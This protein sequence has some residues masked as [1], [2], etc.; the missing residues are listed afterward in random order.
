MGLTGWK[1]AD[2]RQRFCQTANPA[3]VTQ[4]QASRLELDSLTQSLS[5]GHAV[6][7]PGARASG[8]PG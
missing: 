5:R 2:N 8:D 6:S 4:V 3:E 1:A 7:G